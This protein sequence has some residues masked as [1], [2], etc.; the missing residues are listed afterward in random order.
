MQRRTMGRRSVS[1]LIVA[2]DSAM[3]DWHLIG[4]MYGQNGHNFLAGTS[5]RECL[6]VCRLVS[7]VCSPGLV[8]HYFLCKSYL[9]GHIH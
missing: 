7:S 9:L 6:Y 5:L 1:S 3:T 8:S 2:S 4:S